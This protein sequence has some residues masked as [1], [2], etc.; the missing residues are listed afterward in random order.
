MTLDLLAP[1]A[2]D[3]DALALLFTDA[4]TVNTYVDGDVD[5]AEIQAAYEVLRWG[6]TAMNVSPLRLAVV[7]QGESR[8]RLAAHMAGFNRDK[9][10]AAPLVVVAVADPGFHRHLGTLAPHR[11]GLEQDLEPQEERRLEMARTN[12]LIQIGYL[13][14]ALR[15]RG[16]SVGPMAGFDR[17]GLDADLFAGNGWRSELVLTVGWAAAENGTHPRAARL[18]VSDAVV[19]L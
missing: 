4:R 12:T 1:A 8:E 3:D 13:I 11:V 14:V 10:L 2:L 15:A 6:P 19:V 16:L 18:E 17:A 9:T 7:P 5:P